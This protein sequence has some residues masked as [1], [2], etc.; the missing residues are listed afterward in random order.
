MSAPSRCSGRSRRRPRRV[1]T[2]E[3]THTDD[4]RLRWRKTPQALIAATDSIK[5][6]AKAAVKA[7]E[8]AASAAADSAKNMV[9]MRV[10]GA[11]SNAVGIAHSGELARTR[12]Y[13]M[14][15][16]TVPTTASTFSSTDL[17]ERTLHRRAIEAIIWGIPVVNFDLM[18]QSMVRDA[19]GAVNQILYWSRPSDWKNQSLTPNPDTIYFMPFFSTKDVG[20]MV[21]EIPPA[22]DGSITGT[23]MDCLADGA[24]GCRARRRRQRQRRQI[25]DP[26]TGLQGQGS[27]GYIAS[28]V[29][30][31]Q[32]YA[33]LRSILKSRRRRRYRQGRRIRQTDQALSALRPRIRPRR[34]LSTLST[35]LFDGTSPTTSASSSRS[36]AWCSSSRG[37]NAT[38]R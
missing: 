18:F 14:K 1:R 25:S 34:P 9:E 30:T 6:T 35:S 13:E 37:W 19:K 11:N 27:R 12:S 16:Q 29:A 2:S 23:I 17:A 3:R 33:L 32:G 31:Y 24:R 22:D 36:I 10:A 5:E 4:Y 26:A 28:A 21:L 7:T 15:S 20:P 38:G 8:N